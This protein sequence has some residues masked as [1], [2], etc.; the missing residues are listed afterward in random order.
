MRPIIDSIVEA[1]VSRHRGSGR[2]DLNDIAEVIGP[3]AVAYDEVEHIVERLEA[4]GL[5]VGEPL[6]PQDVAVM[7]RIIVSAHRLRAKLRR[8]PTIDE[9][10]VESGH[11]THAV[12]RALEAAGRVVPGARG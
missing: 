5:R 10:A 2:V 8:R 12:R 11:P 1:L 6:T 3:N 4:Q 7:R 9:I